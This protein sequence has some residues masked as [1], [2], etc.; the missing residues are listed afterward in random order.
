MIRFSSDILLPFPKSNDLNCREI[1]C[2]NTFDSKGET[3]TGRKFVLS[4]GS[5]FLC[6]GVTF[7]FFKVIGN[8]PLIKA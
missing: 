7:A 2:S 3:L 4:V 1:T 6:T 5:S 8:F